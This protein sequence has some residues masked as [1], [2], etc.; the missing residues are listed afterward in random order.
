MGYVTRNLISVIVPVH[1]REGY[2]NRCIDSVL[3]QKGV[4]TEIILVD[5]GSTDRSPEICDE[6][7]KKH[8][9]ILVIHQDNQG[10]S[11]A[12]NVGL[13][14]AGGEYIAFLDDDDFL[15]SDS[16]KTLLG[17]QQQSHADMVMGNYARYSDAGE[18]L[19]TFKLP[20]KYSNKML[21][22]RETCELLLFSDKT[23]VLVVSWGKIFRREVWEEIRFPVEIPLGEDQFVFS[24]LMERCQRIYFTD[25]VVYNQV[26]S[27]KSIGRGNFTR[28]K[29]YHSQGVSEVIEY[30]LDKEFYDI[31]LFKFGLGTR[32]LIYCK[33]LLYDDES[34]QEIKRQYVAY[35]KLAARLFP[36]VNLK[37]KLRFILFFLNLDLYAKVRNRV[38]R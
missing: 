24:K 6:Y 2:I 5:D 7:A 36:Y 15:P 13:D 23:H 34:K 32:H 31:A 11:K 30:L 17:L 10:L 19:D 4:K 8:D 16:L 21:S 27:K 12:R 14:T 35:K 18:Y 3:A 9:N 28:K 1:N 22:E 38:A 20:D 25:A 29:I 33:S 37:N 26:F